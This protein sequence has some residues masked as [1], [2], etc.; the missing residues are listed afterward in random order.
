MNDAAP[1]NTG[2]S[3][4]S[5]FQPPTQNPQANTT[6]LQPTPDNATGDRLDQLPPSQL[7]VETAQSQTDS[8]VSQVSSSSMGLSSF[9]PFIVLI[10]VAVLLFRRW[11]FFRPQISPVAVT[12]PEPV[13]E[14]EP[15]PKKTV[16]KPINTRP[17]KKSKSRKKK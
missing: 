5:D 1:T 13:A 7:T 3:N 8:K 16:K 14:S 17:R 6:N 10:V 15:T 12:A 9:L 4:A 11:N 2:A